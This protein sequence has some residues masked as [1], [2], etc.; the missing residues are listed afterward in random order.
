MQLSQGD[1]CFRKARR[2]ASPHIIDRWLFFGRS[3]EYL[4]DIEGLTLGTLTVVV[5][6]VAQILILTGIIHRKFRMIAAFLDG[7]GVTIVD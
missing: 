7:A 6:W 5:I 1:V 3:A 2:A 4:A